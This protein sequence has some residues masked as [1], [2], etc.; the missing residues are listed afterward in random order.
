MS[1]QF[2]KA[3]RQQIKGR[4]ALDGPT[5]AGKTY[6]SLILASALTGA[7]SPL[8]V[9]EGK[10]AFLDTERGSAKLYAD[11]FNFDV[12]ELDYFDPLNYV[13]VIN[14]AE[15]AGYEVLIIDSLSH[16]WDDEGGALDQVDQAAAQL[17]GNSY[18]AWR[19]VTPKHRKLVHR[20]MRADMHVIATMR[21]KMEYDMQKDGQGRTTIKKVGLAPVQRAGIEYEF[22]FVIDMDTDHNAIVSKSR[23]ADLADLVKNKPDA[24]WFAKFYTWLVEGEKPPRTKEELIQYGAGFELSPQEIAAA[25]K[26]SNVQFA[27]DEDTWAMMTNVLAEYAESKNGKGELVK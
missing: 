20:I 23:A 9:P 14:A 19:K 11:L 12:V 4:F 3:V 8:K 10:I 15:D 6:T 27:G 17:K 13:E 24:Q 1:I 21:S 18:A 25:L 7:E 16:A 26:E 22:T 5:G 2:Q